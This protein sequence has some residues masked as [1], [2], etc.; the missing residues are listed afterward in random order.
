MGFSINIGGVVSTTACTTKN[1]NVV[2]GT[3]ASTDATKL[4]NTGGYLTLDTTTNMV[5][6]ATNTPVSKAGSSYKIYV[7]GKTGVGAIAIPADYT[8]GGTTT[9]NGNRLTI[10]LTL[11]DPCL[12]ATVAFTAVADTTYTLGASAVDITWAAATVTPAACSTQNVIRFD[13]EY[14]STIPS[15]LTA[16]DTTYTTAAVVKTNNASANTGWKYTVNTSNPALV[17]THEIK[18]GVTYSGTALN[19]PLTLK[20]IIKDPCDS[21]TVTVT[22]P[23]KIEY[24]LN[25][26]EKS[27]TFAKW[28]TNPTNCQDKIKLK[29]TIPTEAS[30]VVSYTE[31]SRTLKAKTGTAACTTANNCIKEHTLTIGAYGP[32]STLLNVAAGT[33]SATTF[34]LE[35]KAAAGSTTTTNKKP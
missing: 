26:A 23:A 3:G 34:K 32:S 13:Q 11:V 10:E 27:V 19:T 5:K 21:A 7:T 12:T 17:G 1:Y 20:L 2:Y 28:T 31:S 24:T 22:T 18:V 35:I 30:G 16:T 8:S 9:T 14:T 25:A 4:L 33:S 15:V 29:L 6:I